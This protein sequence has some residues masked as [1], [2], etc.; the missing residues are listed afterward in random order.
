MEKY[1]ITL[2]PLILSFVGTALTLRFLIP[3][4]KSR[5]MG[6]KILDIGP[7]WHKDKEG[8]P[9]MG[10]IAFLVFI[11]LSSLLLL[12]FLFFNDYIELTAFYGMLLTVLYGVVNG[13]IGITDDIQKLKKQKNEG[14]T[15]REKYI[16]QLSAALLYIFALLRLSAVNTTI[17]LPFFGVSYDLKIF[18]YLFAVLF[19]TGFCNAV[20]LTDGID[21]LC[22]SVS[23][24]VAVFFAAYTMIIGDFGGT[25]LSSA[26]FG[27]T[28]GFLV[29]NL[30]PAKVFM[31]DTG[32]LFLGAIISGMALTL[33]NPLVL[34]L[35][36]IIYLLEAASVII[37][38]VFF[39]LTGK[40]VF[41]MAPLHHHF[42]KKGLSEGKI[43]LFSVI[44]T[45]VASFLA[46]Y[47]S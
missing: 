46:F 29:Y 23:G 31:G 39:K 37:Q 42:E 5:K 38:V 8:T 2:L 1:I 41:L 21:G 47:L 30:H 40:R 35:V 14:L 32:S 43:T 4:L 6:Q 34:F 15:A 20:N 24:A 22:A 36:G 25:A 12:L 33:E 11:T 17:Y 16:L 3:V 45:A 7:R 9:T 13:I 44:I 27:G 28:L 19:L 10:G 26:I 18:W